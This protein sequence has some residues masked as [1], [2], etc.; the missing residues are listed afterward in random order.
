[1]QKQSMTFITFLKKKTKKIIKTN[2]Y[3]MIKRREVRQHICRLHTQGNS[4]Y[5]RRTTD[6]SFSK[7]GLICD[8]PISI[9]I[10]LG[11]SAP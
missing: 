5:Y 6:T 1:M 2:K 11:A 8:K 3:D 10:K 7:I 9:Q 4:K